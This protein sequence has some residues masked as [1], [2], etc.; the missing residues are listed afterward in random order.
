MCENCYKKNSSRYSSLYKY[1]YVQGV[2]FYIRPHDIVVF[3]PNDGKKI[4]RCL[5]SLHQ[6]QNLT[7]DTARKHIKEN[8][9]LHKERENKRNRS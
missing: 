3:C 5:G 9:K 7:K 1:N 2:V 8:L 6:M 4:V